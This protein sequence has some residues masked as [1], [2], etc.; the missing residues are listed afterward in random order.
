MIQKISATPNVK[1]VIDEV[2]SAT[3]E[4][5]TKLQKLNTNDAVKKYK[6]L[7]R[8][9]SAKEKQLQKEVNVVISKVKK[10]A[11]E[12]EKNLESY[13]K[14]AKIQRAH[15]EKTIKAKTAQFSAKKTT[16]KKTAPKKKVVKKKAVRKA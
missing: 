1:K 10:T 3:I 12:V 4:I 13:K 16:I 6:D 15:I 9:V 2:Q 5:Q 8:K 11:S 7:M 14:K